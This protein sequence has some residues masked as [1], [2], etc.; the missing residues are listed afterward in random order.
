MPKFASVPVKMFRIPQ[1]GIG[2]LNLFDLEYEQEPNQSPYMKNMMYRNGTFS[3]RYGQEIKNNDT[4]DDKVYAVEYFDSKLIV[5]SGTKLYIDGV[6]QTITDEETETTVSLA[7]ETGIFI[8][9]YQALYYYC[10]GTI[11]EYKYDVSDAEW[12]LEIMKPYVPEAFIGCAPVQGVYAT[13]EALKQAHPTGDINDLYAV[14]TAPKYLYYEWEPTNEEWIETT[15]YT[16]GDDLNLLKDEYKC[17]YDADGVSTIFIPYGN[18]EDVV[19]FDGDIEVKINDE[20]TADYTVDKNNKYITFTT[21]PAQGYSNVEIKYTLKESVLKT[22][23]DRL[24]ACKYHVNYGANG[25][26]RLFMA[27]GGASKIFYSD[28]YDATYFPENNWILIGSTEK[29]VTGFCL[30]YNVL[31]AFKPK[32][33]YSLYSYQVTAS[34]VASDDDALIGTEAFG[35]TIVNSNMGCDCPNTIQLIN[36]QATWFSSID[37]VCTLVSTNIA[38]ERN[39]RTIS[40]NIERTNNFNVK[41]ILDF[42]IEKDGFVPPAGGEIYEF[43]NQIQS[44]DFDNKYFLVFPNNGACYMWDYAI[45]PFIYTSSKVTDTRDLDWYLFDRFYCK[46]FVQV[47]KDLKY[48]TDYEQFKKSLITLNDKTFNDLDFNNDG[49][50]DGISSYYMTPFLQFNAFEYLKTVKNIYVQV[51]G[52]TAS[53]IDMYYYT[54]ESSEKEPEPESIRIGGKIWDHFSWENFEWLVISWAST[55]RRKCSLKKIQMCAFYFENVDKV[56]ASVAGRD[57][58]ISNIAL[59][60]QLVKTVK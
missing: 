27:G 43:Y 20:V 2:G 14:G 59:D 47:G 39:V 57:M 33:I 54:D 26:S 56:D 3:K 12:K 35:A 10:G 15:R 48:I 5:H 7:E 16:R 51:R 60:Y 50:P 32:E 22:E 45:S 6:E 41:G 13:L 17:I 24:L 18:E 34:M 23:K 4:Y 55:F 29:D 28:V 31:I 44:A 46:Q 1:P 52:D 37:G 42:K 19:D 49:E 36:N 8:K 11:L 53:V 25:N 38:D 21:A 9:F 30:Q 40:R 58:S